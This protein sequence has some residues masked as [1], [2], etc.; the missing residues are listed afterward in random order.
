MIVLEHKT[1]NVLFL[2]G[3]GRRVKQIDPV[4]M[5]KARVQRDADQTVLLSRRDRQFTHSPHL[6]IPG[7][8]DFYR[9]IAL[10]IEHSAVV[11]N[12]Q[13]DRVL[14]VGIEYHLLVIGVDTRSTIA[15]RKPRRVFDSAEQMLQKERLAIAFPRMPAAGIPAPPPVIFMAPG[16]RVVNALRPTAITI[17]IKHRQYMYR[18][19]W[20]ALIVIPLVPAVPAPW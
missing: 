13:G 20:I 7:Q 11:S 16:N 10:D 15:R 9:S 5:C 4:V 18:T 6:P 2:C 3:A 17:L 1:G 12:R 8:V 14:R 19:A